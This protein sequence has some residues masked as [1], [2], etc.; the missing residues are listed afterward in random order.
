MS[1]TRLK[2]LCALLVLLALSA[3]G[4][5]DDHWYDRHRDDKHAKHE[6]ERSRAESRSAGESRAA[7]DAHIRREERYRYNAPYT[8]NNGAYNGRYSPYYG[9]N[10]TPYYGG[11][12]TSAPYGTYGG[13]G[14]RVPYG[15]GSPAGTY[16]SYG[17]GN[18]GQTAYNNG[19]QQG[20]RR[21]EIDRSTGHSYRPTHDD[22]Y[23]DGDGGY[24]HT[25]GDKNMYKQSFRQGY[26][27]GYQRGYGRG[28]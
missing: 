4:F 21:G 8:T 24:N 5:A 28:Y 18:V 19:Y 13:Y 14:N 10:N 25:M 27:Q 3:A 12:Y 22:R 7:R 6:W 11:P 2:A 15:Y 9:G 16:G 20:M 23:N 26:M 1:S 17:N